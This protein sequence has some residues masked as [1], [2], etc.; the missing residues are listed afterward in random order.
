MI[1]CSR[2]SDELNIELNI[3]EKLDAM[4]QSK[5][6]VTTQIM[7]ETLCKNEMFDVNSVYKYYA[8]N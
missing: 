2:S 4:N 8:D 1:R 6:C 3:C 7:R 5:E